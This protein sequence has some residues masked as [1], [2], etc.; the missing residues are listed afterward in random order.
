MWFNLDGSI[1]GEVA[2]S[3]D[4]ISRGADILE[5]FGVGLTVWLCDS[6]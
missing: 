5:G 6:G 2:V 1:G 3:R 4:G